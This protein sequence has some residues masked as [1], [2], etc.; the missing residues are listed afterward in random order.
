MA[1]MIFL[2]PGLARAI[3]LATIHPERSKDGSPLFLPERVPWSV[4][5]KRHCS[6]A[7]WS[8][9]FLPSS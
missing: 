7:L 6:P 8:G 1:K 9:F 3:L 2:I 5:A 4:T